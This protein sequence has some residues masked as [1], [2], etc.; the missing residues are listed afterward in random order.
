MNTYFA[1]F[2]TGTSELVQGQLE[3]L[4]SVS[5]LKVYDGLII[6]R[7]PRS[8]KEIQNIRYFNNLFLLLAS[9]EDRKDGKNLVERLMQS[10]V[11]KGIKTPFGFREM[12]RGKK[13]FKIFAAVENETVSINRSLLQRVENQIKRV[14]GLR[15]NIQRPDLEFWFM[16]R[17]EGLGLF[18]LRLTKVRKENKQRKKG[19]LRTELAHLLCLASELK[20]SDVI[21][22]PFAGH[23]AIVIERARSFPYQKIYASDIDKVLV[24]ELQEKIKNIKNIQVTQADALRLNLLDASIDKIITDPPWGEYREIPNLERFYEG[25]LKEFN[26]ILKTNGIIVI[27]IGAKETFEGV[28]QNIFSQTFVMNSKYDTLVSGK[29]AAVYKITRINR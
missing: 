18:G 6:F 7:F 1:T 22:D 26:R 16:A 28:L 15:L 11:Q 8:W 4:K 23:G 27:L 12:I 10:A 19:E 9:R 3:M 14:S 20:P 13:S 17:R 2:I 29:K 24:Q 21:C 5:I 25:I